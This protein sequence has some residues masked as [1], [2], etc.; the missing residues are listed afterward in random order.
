MG[1]LVCSNRKWRVQSRKRMQTNKDGV[2]P[3]VCT[4]IV[5]YAFIA[6]NGWNWHLYSDKHRNSQKDS[7]HPS[8]VPGHRTCEVKW[9]SHF[10]FLYLPI[11]V[12]MDCKQR[13]W[14]LYVSFWNDQMLLLFAKSGQRVT[15]QISRLHNI[16][17]FRPEPP[18]LPTPGTGPA[19]ASV[20]K[21][22]KSW[23]N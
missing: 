11:I 1:Y 15:F 6:E 19:Q 22:S 23:P 21:L 12:I 18:K 9:L 10:W 5:I 17:L 16:H 8:T 7:H 13:V 2:E 20:L 14:P 3:T 4:K